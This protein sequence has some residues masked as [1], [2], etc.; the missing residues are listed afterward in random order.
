MD[1][2]DK[3]LQREEKP[4]AAL[5]G[6]YVGPEGLMHCRVC[7]APRQCRIRLWDRERIVPCLCRC[8]EE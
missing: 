7:H 1:G 6:E 2:A 8:Q 5:A 4:E 3:G